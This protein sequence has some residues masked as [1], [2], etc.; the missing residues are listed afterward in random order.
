LRTAFTSTRRRRHA[1]ARHTTTATRFKVCAPHQGMAST[2]RVYGRIHP[3]TLKGNMEGQHACRDFFTKIP[4]HVSAL[5]AF[6]TSLHPQ[7][8]FVYQFTTSCKFVYLFT[9]TRQVCVL[10]VLLYINIG[11]II[12]TS[13]SGKSNQTPARMY[14]GTS[15]IFLV[16]N[17]RRAN[18]RSLATVLSHL[19]ANHPMLIPPCYS[20]VHDYGLRRGLACDQASNRL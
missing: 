4:S 2:H 19:R 6:C 13:M 17:I 20:L 5:G 10:P 18:A 16:T 14:L 1:L 3:A 15:Y 11:K 7:L 8:K 9:L 12:N